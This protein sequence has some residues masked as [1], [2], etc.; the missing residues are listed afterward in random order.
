[1]LGAA[2]AVIAARRIA[3]PL[4][5]ERRTP[6]MAV[7]IPGP[8][9]LAVGLEHKA[10]NAEIRASGPVRRWSPDPH[11]THYA[12]VGLSSIFFV[13]ISGPSVRTMGVVFLRVHLSPIACDSCRC[14]CRLL[15]GVQSVEGDPVASMLLRR[16]SQRTEH[17]IG[18]MKDETAVTGSPEPLR[19]PRDARQAAHSVMGRWLDRPR[20][21]SLRFMDGSAACSLLFSSLVSCAAMLLT[22][23]ADSL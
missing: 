15:A 18:C 22:H 20:F 11:S 7:M 4:Q 12:F 21:F 17:Q 8:G 16:M 2:W 19:T 1:M 13:P 23:S 3:S 5:N 6:T 14:S 9:S 10:S